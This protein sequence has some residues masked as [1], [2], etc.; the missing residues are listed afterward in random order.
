MDIPLLI[1]H[2]NDVLEGVSMFFGPGEAQ[3]G[4]EKDIKSDKK[5]EKAGFLLFFSANQRC[6]SFSEYNCIIPI[7]FYIYH[8]WLI[9][10][11]KRVLVLEHDKKRIKAQKKR[12]TA[13]FTQKFDSLGRFNEKQSCVGGE[14]GCFKHAEACESVK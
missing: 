7:I 14:L 2:S 6:K 1:C 12:K 11:P 10:G 9:I 5:R 3:L 13:V 8:L 4:S